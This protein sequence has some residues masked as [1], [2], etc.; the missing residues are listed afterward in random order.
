MKPRHAPTMPREAP[1]PRFEH[2]RPTCVHWGW[3]QDARRRGGLVWAGCAEGCVGF[4][5]EAIGS[6]KNE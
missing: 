2:D 1:A 3:C 5:V 6:K 4:L